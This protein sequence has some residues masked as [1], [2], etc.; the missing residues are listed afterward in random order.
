MWLVNAGVLAVFIAVAAVGLAERKHA[1]RGQ[2][3]KAPP[4][5]DWPGAK[6]LMARPGPWLLGFIFTLYALQWFAVMTWLPTF[7][8]E[9]QQRSLT[10]A[11]LFAAL[12]VFVNVAGNLAAGWLMVRGGL[13]RWLLIGFS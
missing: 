1:K 9:T 2:G 13:P 4:A 6:A 5:F 11:S 12:V 3:A 10:N 8:I 7:L